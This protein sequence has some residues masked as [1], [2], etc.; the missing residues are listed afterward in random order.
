[1]LKSAIET[2]MGIDSARR[3]ANR[4]RSPSQEI[5]GQKTPQPA[6]TLKYLRRS[7]SLSSRMTIDVPFRFPRFPERLTVELSADY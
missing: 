1:M 4:T 2:A 6:R 3:I 5:K 7:N